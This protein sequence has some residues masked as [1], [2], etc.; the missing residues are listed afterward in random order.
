M[1][2]LDD[3]YDPADGYE[4]ID[5]A[6]VEKEMKDEEIAEEKLRKKLGKDIKSNKSKSFKTRL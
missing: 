5:K 6:K 2:S 3:I 1:P 4:I